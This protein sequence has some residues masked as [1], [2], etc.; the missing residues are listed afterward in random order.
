MSIVKAF[1]H[2]IKRNSFLIL[3]DAC[4]IKSRDW[5]VFTEGVII[6]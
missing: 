3:Q 5:A 4:L 2:I 6:Q 1:D